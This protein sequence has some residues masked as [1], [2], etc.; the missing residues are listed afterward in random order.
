M[1]TAPLVP[2]VREV[3][4]VAVVCVDEAVVEDEL[5]MLEVDDMIVGAAVVLDD[6]GEEVDEVV[7]TTVPEGLGL[8]SV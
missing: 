7:D 5:L 2:V 3:A 4:V 6:A 8:G 1:E